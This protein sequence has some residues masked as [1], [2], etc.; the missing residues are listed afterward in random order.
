MM[1]RKFGFF[2]AAE[3]AMARAANAKRHEKNFMTIV[4]SCLVAFDNP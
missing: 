4:L 3:E 2:S 1:T